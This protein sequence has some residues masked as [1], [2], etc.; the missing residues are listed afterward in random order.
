M[1]RTH[2]VDTGSDNADTIDLSDAGCIGIDP[3]TYH[4]AA[5]EKLTSLDSELQ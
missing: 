4:P 3:D 2:R 1:T 5:R